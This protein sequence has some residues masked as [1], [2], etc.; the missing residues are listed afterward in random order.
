MLTVNERKALRE[1]K[2]GLGRVGKQVSRSSATV[3][4]PVA[5]KRESIFIRAWLF[6]FQLR[7]R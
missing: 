2:S 5:P 7:H 1:R 6:W 3:S 4:A